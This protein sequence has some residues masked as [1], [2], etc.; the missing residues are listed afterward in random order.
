MKRSGDS[1][2]FAGAHPAGGVVQQVKLCTVRRL[3]PP[4]EVASDPLRARAFGRNATRWMIGSTITWSFFDADPVSGSD[5]DTVD[6]R[7]AVTRAWQRWID[8][9][10]N[11]IISYVDDPTTATVRIA[12]REQ[13]ASYSYVGTDNKGIAVSNYTM[14]LGWDVT[15]NGQPGTAEH[16]IGHAL[17]LDHEHQH[18]QCPLVWNVDAVL[19]SYRTS[20]GWSDDDIK[21]QVLNRVAD[22][23][24]GT[25]YDSTSIMH[26]PFTK[27]LI[28]APP[29]Y[30]EQGISYN[31]HISPLDVQCLLQMYPPASNF[32][33]NRL[34]SATPPPLVL[35]KVHAWEA[36]QPSN[37]VGIDTMY[38]LHFKK[39][40]SHVIRRI[41]NA[42]VLVVVTATVLGAKDQQ[43]AA[44]M[45]MDD[46]SRVH[47]SLIKAQSVEYLMKIRLIHK[48]KDEKFVLL[49][50]EQ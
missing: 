38:S 14:N 49:F 48:T 31:D 41:G 11:L 37:P 18:P 21:Q 34:S 6:Q 28:S 32:V 27:D 26:Y 19:Q 45:L 13:G 15:D 12:F 2:P 33:K 23:T 1:A 7:A 46:S 40:G 25:A 44:G 4:P 20:Q 17:G 9:G 43:I 8:T 10:M 36:I 39:S 22:P 3:P 24:G 42:D 5:W 29:P 16:E 35:T 47:L 50:C 30:S